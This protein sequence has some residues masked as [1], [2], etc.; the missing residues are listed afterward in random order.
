MTRAFYSFFFQEDAFRAGQVRNMG[1]VEGDQVVDDHNWEQIKRGGDA[2]IRNWISEQMQRCD[3]AIVLVGANTASRHWVDYE[4]RYA[5]DNYKPLL[6]IRIHGLS[7]VRTGTSSAGRN[8]F[9]S[10]GLQDGRKLS[11]LVPLHNPAGLNSKDV[12]AS[13]KA[14]IKQ[15]IA[16]APK[17]G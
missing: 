3:V 5:W 13:I 1:Q 14:N 16:A 10:V 2:A 9:D 8:P 7:D 11:S 15:W 12:Y 4:I 6:G 17:R